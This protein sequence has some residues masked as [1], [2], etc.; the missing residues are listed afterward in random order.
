MTQVEI[1]AAILWLGVV[2]YSL[3]AGA[4]FGAGFLDL[5]A[6]RDDNAT[7]QRRLIEHSIGPVWEANHVWLIF[8]LVVMW[9]CF[10]VLF[11]SVFSTLY[12]PLSL[13]GAG[14]IIR[15][16][17]FAFR[18]V[19]VADWQ[20]RIAGVGFAISSILTPFFL[21]VSAGAVASGGVP[22]GI[23]GAGP[24]ASWF[25]PVP[26]FTGLLAIATCVFLAATFLVGDA[27]RA[28]EHDLA[29]SFTN[30][31]VVAGAVA[32][33]IS[34]IG[35][36]LLHSQASFLYHGLLTHA[37][38]LVVLSAVAGL[39]TIALLLTRHWIAARLSAGAAVAAVLWAWAVAQFPYALAP[40]RS[41]PGLELG[42]VA[43]LPSVLG[44][45]LTS[46][47]VGAIVLVPSLIALY[48]VVSSGRWIQDSHG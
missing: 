17:A 42:Q 4:D 12:V 27:Q 28:G 40:T 30:K 3:F 46:L 34:M 25:S 31:A 15:G 26:V 38:G 10:P 6:G 16:S 24:I 45:T 48:R 1:A 43:A 21:G 23:A 7:R 5:V 33:L 13:A 47:L 8:V 32:G 37:L 18:K 14:V 36:L 39:A 19:L 22:P 35:L 20:R 9:T 41:H 11:A 29:K 44:A 2:L